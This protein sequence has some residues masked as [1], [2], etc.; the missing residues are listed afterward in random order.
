MAGF[1]C[2]AVRRGVVLCL[3]VLFF[4]ALLSCAAVLS[5]VFFLLC[6][7]PVCGAPGSFCLFWALPCCVLLLGVALSRCVLVLVSPALC[8]VVLCC[9]GVRLSVLCCILCFVV[10]TRSCLASSA[11]VVGCCTLSVLGR[12]AVSSC[13]ATCGPGAV[14]PCAVFLGWCACAVALCAVLSRPC[15]AG[16]CCV[17]LPLVFGRLLLALALL[18]CLLVG[19]GG[20]WCRVSVVLSLSGCVARR[21][22]VLCGGSWCS[23]TLC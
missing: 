8:P 4:F 15:G 12:S 22:V 16:G 17:L 1:V 19:P 18:C 2:R 11:A 3:V 13:C 10:V 20:S 9:A 14:F 23:A 5:A 21:P 7:L 6:S